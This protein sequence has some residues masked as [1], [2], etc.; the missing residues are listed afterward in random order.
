MHAFDFDQFL[1]ETRTVIRERTNRP[2]FSAG[3]AETV[4]DIGATATATA[5]R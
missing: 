2:L 5:V 1:Q 4:V 3:G